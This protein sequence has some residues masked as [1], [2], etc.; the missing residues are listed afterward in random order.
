M[1]R[2]FIFFSLV[3]FAFSH[4]V[5]A[6]ETPGSR[7]VERRMNSLVI[8][9]LLRMEETSEIVDRQSGREFILNFESELT[10]VFCD[11][12]SSGDFLQQIPVRQYVDCF[13]NADGVSRFTMATLEFRNVR[14]SGW[15]FENGRWYCTVLL[16]KSVNYFDEN[17]VSF[18]L[19]GQNSEQTGF[20]IS[21]KF[22]FDESCTGCRIAEIN[23]SNAG[24]F[25][26]LPP[27]YLVVQK[28]EAADDAKRDENIMIGNSRIVFNEFGQGYASGTE[29]SFW[30]DDMK[31]NRIVKSRN[32]RY[33]YVQFRYKPRHLRLRLRN[34]FAPFSAYSF[35]GRTEIL[36]ES[37]SS[38]YSVGLDAGYSLT[39]SR[40]FKIGFF[41]GIGVS[42]S[43]ISL[44]TLPY[45]Y[46]YSTS[47]SGDNMPHKRTYQIDYATQGASFSD[48]CVPVYL[49]PEFRL[50]RSV[51]LFF[52]LGAKVYFN[53]VAVTDP[54]HVS[55]H[56]YGEYEDGTPVMDGVYGIGAIDSDF[57]YMI[58]AVTFMR[59]PVD[60]ALIGDIGF[61]VNLYDRTVYLE[62]R[63]GYEFGLTPTYT[64]SESTF[65]STNYNGASYP[66]VYDYRY[67]DI[68]TRPLADCIS[69]KRKAL[70]FNIGLML[71]L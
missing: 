4:A 24:D 23:C 65:C 7:S 2:K 15:S 33:E 58:N 62:V 36:A 51:S 60:I 54:F 25:E 38:A 43:N 29:I 50:H 48:L 61:N 70:W 28:N 6:Q 44:K 49:S 45:R 9:A 13:L 57:K 42:F 17:F 22:V 66:L 3:V 14:K 59:N 12:F 39:A 64:S 63:A 67:G 5:A 10:P 68:A 37:S 35:S 20:D 71:K 69:F 31:V 56:V 27:H 18:P 32:E 52:D 53:T 30:D 19:P 1:L 41:T 34:E 46:S 40:A 26:A 16:E 55:G 11:L 8:D 21:V 47:V